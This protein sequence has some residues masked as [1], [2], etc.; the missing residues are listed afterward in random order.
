ML[1]QTAQI[2]LHLLPLRIHHLLTIQ[3]DPHYSPRERS[4]PGHIHPLVRR[5]SLHAHVSLAHDPLL[6]RVQD[7]LE[8]ALDDDA[9]VNGHGAVEGRFDAGAKVDHPDYGAGFVVEGWLF[10]SY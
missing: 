8:H 6:T 4:I 7:Q 1:L 10:S 9:V 3:Q 2:P 5:R